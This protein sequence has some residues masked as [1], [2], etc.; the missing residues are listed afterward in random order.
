MGNEPKDQKS[1]W[2]GLF[3]G[4]R[5][6][7]LISPAAETGIGAAL[8]AEPLALVTAPLQPVQSVAADDRLGVL[9]KVTIG[10]RRFAC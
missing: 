9:S 7:G 8:A 10:R 1:F 4:A 3:G 5:D 2:A 6:A